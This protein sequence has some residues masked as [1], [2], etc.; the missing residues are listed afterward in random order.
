MVHGQQ[1]QQHNTEAHSSAGND[2][3]H[4]RK[5]KKRKAEKKERREERVKEE[6]DRKG[7][8]RMKGKLRKE[9]DDR[10]KIIQNSPSLRDPDSSWREEEQLEHRS[11]RD[12]TKDSTASEGST[13]ALCSTEPE[14]WLTAMIL[15]VR[16]I[17][18]GVAEH[19]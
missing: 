8:R 5:K 14:V 10:G 13:L 12:T 4:G 11:V 6:V 19:A 2:N 7:E 9:E 15:S 17:P 18:L 3:N 1:Q 16:R